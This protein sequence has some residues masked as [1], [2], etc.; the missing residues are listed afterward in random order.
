MGKA[1]YFWWEFKIYILIKVYNICTGC[2]AL[3]LPLNGEWAIRITTVALACDWAIY[4]CTSGDEQLI[5]KICSRVKLAWV[6]HEPAL[7]TFHLKLRS[8]YAW[9]S[10]HRLSEHLYSSTTAVLRFSLCILLKDALLQ[11][12]LRFIWHIPKPHH[13]PSRKTRTKVQ[14]KPVICKFLFVSD[15]T[16]TVLCCCSSVVTRWKS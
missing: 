7:I 10:S 1:L 8:F 13:L 14:C 3:W 2:M 6:E 16:L 9:S 12:Q 4:S 15:N 11:Y 5:E